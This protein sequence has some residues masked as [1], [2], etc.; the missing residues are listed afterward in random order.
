M[1]KNFLV[2]PFF[3]VMFSCVSPGPYR[4]IQANENVEIIGS[5]ETLFILD[6][7][8]HNTWELIYHAAYTKLLEEA[9]KEYGNNIDIRGVTIAVINNRVDGIFRMVEFSANGIVISFEEENL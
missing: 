7:N 2:L 4:P 8:Q 1:K 9:W 5:V 6:L 3:M